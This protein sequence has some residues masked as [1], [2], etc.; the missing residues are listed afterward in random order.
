MNRRKRCDSCGN[1]FLPF[2]TTQKVC[3]YVCAIEFNQRKK[4]EEKALIDGL[5]KEKKERVK[6]G[7]SLA[8]TK[9]VVHEYVRK[10]DKGKPCVSC[11]N[12]W[13]SNFQACHYHKA[14]LFTA[15]KFDLDN[16][17]AGC[18]SCN[19][20][21][22]G[23]LDEYKLRLPDRIGQERFDALNKRAELS[24]RFTKK[25]SREELAEIRKEVKILMKELNEKNGRL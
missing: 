10:R 22:D 15:I 19:I 24:K 14:E 13:S 17:S 16:I 2:K 12:L 25:W 11:G 7:F 21:K 23:N 18:K 8:V 5:V 20:H 6:L 9:K 1:L 4:K 3:S